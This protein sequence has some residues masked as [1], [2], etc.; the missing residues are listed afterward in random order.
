MEAIDL[1][2]GTVTVVAGN[3]QACGARSGSCIESG[4]EV[5]ALQVQFHEPHGIAFDPTGNL[6]VADLLNNRIVRIAR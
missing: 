1:G 5:T 4:G 6:Y 3:G 2:A